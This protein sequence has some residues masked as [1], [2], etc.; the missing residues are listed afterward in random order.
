MSTFLR[1]TCPLKVIEH[2]VSATQQLGNSYVSASGD[3]FLETSSPINSVVFTIRQ[4]IPLLRFAV[5]PAYY[6]ITLATCQDSSY[7]IGVFREERY[8]KK[9]YETL[10]QYYDDN[11]DLK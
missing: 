9:C 1:I 6:R 7:C 4:S 3:I 2:V 11:C 8:A 5:S 10:F